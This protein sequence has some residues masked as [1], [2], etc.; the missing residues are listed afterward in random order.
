MSAALKTK[1][2]KRSLFKE[3]GSALTHLAGVIL[4]IAGAAPLIIK[5]AG[6]GAATV[7]ASG[8]FICSMISLYAASTLYHSVYASPKS[9]KRLKKLDHIMIYFLIAGTYTPICVL[10]LPKSSGIPLLV[11]IWFFALSGLVLTLFWVNSPKWINSVIYIM[12]GWLCLFAFKPL[13]FSLPRRAF[14]WLLAGGII[15]TVGGI[16]YALKLPL[17][18]QLHKNFGSH[19]IFHLFVLAGSICHY[20]VIYAYLA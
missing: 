18:N 2:E 20:Y 12:M 19:E 17:F 4:S 5:S 8:I 15:Y 10:A 9:T 3:P 13:F 7:A 16:I 6:D 11:M 1:G 14:L